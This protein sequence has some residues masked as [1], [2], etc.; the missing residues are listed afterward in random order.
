MNLSKFYK[1]KAIGSIVVLVVVF[2]GFLIFKKNDSITVINETTNKQEE[3]KEISI[4]KETIKEENFTGSYPTISGSSTLAVEAR[5]FV[6]ETVAVFKE[7]A[8]K[9]VPD[10]REKFGDAAAPASYS[11]DIEA[12]HL[13]GTKTEA[14]VMSVYTYTGGAHGS[15][16]YK[17]VNSNK[18]DDKILSLSDI[19]KAEQKEAFTKL[20]KDEL[21]RLQ[22]EGTIAVFPEDVKN[23]KFDSFENWSLTSENLTIYFDQYEVGP[24]ALGAL[25]FPIS[26]EKLKSFLKQEYL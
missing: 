26:I 17:V 1:Y 20:V 9:D 6:K 12:K 15:S 23:L 7:Q 10:M 3:V 21:G 19:V 25:A 24:G 2:V 8:D 13:I 16:S 18:A 5:D 11:I 4:I 14:I 22:V